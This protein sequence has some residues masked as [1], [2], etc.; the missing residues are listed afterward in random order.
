MVDTRFHSSSGPI[1][2]GVVLSTLGR[3][4]AIDDDRVPAL[5]L[6][7]AAELGLAGPDQL[8]FAAQQDYRDALAETAA[9]AVIVPPSLQGDVPATAIA[10]VDERPHDLFVDL[11][12]RLY[13]LGTRGMAKAQFE[14]TGASPHIEEGVRIGSNVVLGAGV[15]I[16]RNTVIGPNT[17]I[18]R[19]VAIGRNTVIGPNVSIECAYLGNNVVIHAGARIG[20][21]GF[22][23]LGLTRTNRKIPQ[24]GRV[25]VQDAVEIGANSTVD[26][27][28][29]GDTVI[30]EGTKIDNL[31]HVGHNT[32][33]GRY[34]LIAGTC[35]IA[36]SATIGDNVMIGGGAGIAGHLR[37][38]NGSIV[39]AWAMVIND[40]PPGGRV[41]GIPA[42]DH[43]QWKREQVLLRRL[44]KR[45][46]E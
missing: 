14:P 33:I 38:G 34:C 40:V 4:I 45:G 29:L 43:R 35:G 22:G 8:A 3:E 26:R 36:G 16:G 23:W 28:A 20:T 19:G 44:N 31:V 18:G 6:T 27:G 30:G 32:R 46:Q 25:I 13:P 7:G 37:V 2:L 11:L 39:S 24:L 5:V 42:Q 1:A 21:E 41:A 15:E 12:E 9:G 10:I 17:V